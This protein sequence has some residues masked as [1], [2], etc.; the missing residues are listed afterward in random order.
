MLSILNPRRMVYL[1]AL[2]CAAIAPAGHAATLAVTTTAD[3][4]AADGFCSLR[5]AIQAVNAGA[6]VNECMPVA[7]AFGASDTIGFDIPPLTD[8][9]CIVGT[10]VCTISPTSALP[11]ITK[12]VVID[13]YTQPGAVPNT[14]AANAYPNALGLDTQI[15]IQLDGINTPANTDGL[16]LSGINSRLSGLAIYNYHGGGTTLNVAAT[17]AVTTTAD[18]V[19]ADGF[20]SLREAIQAVNTGASVQECVPVAGV[21]GTS[22]TIGFDIPSATDAGCN[23]GTGVCTISPTS[24]MLITS[25]VH[26]DGYTQPGST[27]NTLAANAYPN[28]LG[29]D[30]QIKIQLDGIGTPANWNGLELASPNSRIDG[31]S[32]YNFRG[33]GAAIRVVSTNALIDGNFIGIMADGTTSGGVNNSDYGVKISAASNTVGGTIAA[34]RNLIAGHGVYDVGV[35]GVDSNSIVGNLIGTDISGTL[36]R[37]ANTGVLISGPAGGTASSNTITKNVISAGTGIKLWSASLTTVS[38]NTIGIA[39]G[40]AP[41]GIT[42][43]VSILTTTLPGMGNNISANGIAN[44]VVNDGINV[45]GNIGGN[46]LDANWIWNNAGL[47]INLRP[48]G[49]AIFTVTPNDAPASLDADT[50]PN[51]L[52]NFPVIASATVNG[53][54]VDIVFTLDSAASTSYAISAYANDACDASGYGEGQYF[55]GTS[56]AFSTDANGHLANT[57]SYGAMPTGW[58]VGKFVTMLAH[59]TAANNTSEFSACVQIVAVGTPPVMGNVPNQNA[60]VGTA[61]SLDLSAFVSL[62]DGNP[63]TGYAVASGA[64]PPGLALVA[65]TGVISGTPTTAGTYNVTV[66]ATDINGVSNAD[67]IQFVVAAAPPPGTPPVMGNVPNQSATVGTAFSLALS[68]YVTLTQANPILSYAIASGALPPGLALVAATGVI[69][70]TPS[71]AGTYNVTVTA[72]DVDGASNADAIQFVVAAA[73]PPGITSYTAPSATGTGNITASFSGGGATCGYTTSQF[74][75]LTGNPASPPAG[76]APAGYTFPQGLF[77]FTTSGCT[78]G[79]TITMTITYPQAIPAG[80]VYWKYG[81]APG[82]VVPHWYQLP[83][84]I[85]GNTVTFSITDGGLGDDDLAINGTIVDQGQGVA[86]AAAR[87]AFRHCPNGV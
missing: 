46:R 19:A 59:D 3:T 16:W 28:A 25:T 34:R 62:T 84:T 57:L 6:S 1:F 30:T 33:T 13:G 2:I 20:C 79:S 64:L 36:A 41:L 8:A 65:G 51:G 22:D 23:V 52:Q 83:A 17:L 42:G 53:G 61:F 35:E 72:S 78:P 38:G 69:S 56:P 4:V 66:T 80:A 10:G 60:T 18:T 45:Y 26:I 81:P 40:G 70:G 71:A 11:I 73:P 9:G 14:L 48:V 86:E 49:E 21:F 39:V 7:G 37:Q 15:K 31:L 58:A 55:A 44:S 68:G 43:G 76:T 87:L 47:G 85:V 74:I 5:E 82:N 75:P 63:V 27:A 67:A 77:D 12:T 29:L 50:G 24:G 54:G 32:I